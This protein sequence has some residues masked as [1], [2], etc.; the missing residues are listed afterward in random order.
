MTE[1]QPLFDL[2]GAGPFGDELA[3]R[4]ASRICHD[5]VSPLG[6]IGNGLELLFLSGLEPSPESD[7]IAQSVESAGARIRFFRLAF[8]AAV[9]DPV[10]PSE[11]AGTLGG[12]EKGS[13]LTFDWPSD[14]EVA[15]PEVKALFL[16]LL[17]LDSAMPFGGRVQ[18]RR[19]GSAWSVDAQG[20]RL[21]I[22]PAAWSAVGPERGTPPESAALV[23][24]ALLPL[25]LAALRWH[26]ELLFEPDRILAR[27]S[28]QPGV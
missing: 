28:H 2:Q 16:L 12:L 14:G 11:I 9:G 17:C 24:F 7:L 23:Q 26:L 21:R 10:A 3:A 27:L 6:A 25:A 20:R 15:R 18:V 19:C 4:T 13:R 22:D 1:V 5:L 8:G